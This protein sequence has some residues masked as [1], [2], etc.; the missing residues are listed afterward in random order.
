MRLGISMNFKSGDPETIARSYLAAGYS[1]AGC[2]TVSLDQ[3][4]RIK[5]I[6]EA[7]SRHDLCLAEVG[8]W[9][10]LLDPDPAKRAD[11]LAV[12]I[13]KMALAEEIGARCCVN[14]AGSFNPD[15]WDGPHPHNL[16]EEAF[17]LTVENVRKIIDEVKPRR[18][19]FT[20]E[21]MPWVIPDS[22]D[23]YLKLIQAVDR[24]MFGVHLDPVNMINC[25]ARYY[26]NAGFLREC[27]AR[28]G[29]WIVSCHAKDILMS[30]QL[31]VHLQEV[32]PGLGVL[33][34]PTFLTEL[35]RLPDDVPLILEHLP[36]EEYPLAQ[37]Y[38]LEK[39]EACGIR[40]HKSK[41]F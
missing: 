15:R 33:D 26:D 25:P 8:I 27:F 21:T 30:D 1:A 14:I 13:Q 29:K 32:R 10:N 19:Y 9:N 36:A 39:A 20:L 40:F 23:S 31:T 5:A 18:S 7:F 35:D 11:N 3:P 38:V 16:S 34:Y 28:L 24:P 6:R 4:E 2:P 37:Q 41:I 17:E 12:N 22:P